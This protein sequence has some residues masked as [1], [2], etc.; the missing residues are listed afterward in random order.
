MMSARVAPGDPDGACPAAIKQL[1]PIF[2]GIEQRFSIQ[3]WWLGQARLIIDGYIYWCTST[4][5]IGGVGLGDYLAILGHSARVRGRPSFQRDCAREQHAVERANIQLPPGAKLS[6]R[7]DDSS[8][9]RCRPVGPLPAGG[10]KSLLQ[11][12]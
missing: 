9:N 11:S 4:A 2:A 7:H 8:G 3:P 1:K 6:S 12:S 10:N 5:A